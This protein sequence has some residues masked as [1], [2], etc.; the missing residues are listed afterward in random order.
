MSIKKKILLTLLLVLF[1][2][3]SLVTSL[4]VLS[5]P[6]YEF[7]ETEDGG[8]QFE[9]FNGN[10]E[11]T[12]LHID[13]VLEKTKTSQGTEWVA[14][15]SRPITSVRS[16]TVASVE[17]L[18]DVYIGAAV[19][20][21]G[22]AAF[23]N[24]WNLK[25]Y[26]V[27]K[28]NKY[29]CDVD[30]VLF[31][32]DMKVLV[33]YPPAKCKDEGADTTYAIPAG[34]E[35]L[36]D[37]SF[38]KC[39][40]L[41]EVTIPEGVKE[42]GR[43]VFFKCWDLNLVELPSTIETLGPDCFSFC[44]SMKYAFFIPASMKSIDHHAFYKSDALE[45]FYVECDES[46]ISLGSKWMPKSENSFSAD[47]AV[48][49]AARSE[50]EAYNAKRISEEKP[51]VE[52]NNP[53]SSDN[54]D[55]PMNDKAVILLI[56]FVFIPGFIMIGIEVIRKLFKED[57]LMT[58]NGRAKLEKIKAEKEAIHLAYVNGEYADEEPELPP[59]PS[60]GEEDDNNG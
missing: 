25:A 52:E 58:K 35:R 57:F 49:S 30:G 12:E 3:T 4:N 41:T 8:W 16:N 24:L 10:A 23:T 36:A 48:F 31:T 18:T 15:E 11:I 45:A 53:E 13:K 55:N 43:M 56:I 26:H 19:K 51:P 27:D 20:D 14:D 34:V 17:Y 29:Y 59:E 22:E 1:V 47:D 2:G 40:A 6:T 9:G 33:S 54:S 32:K 50:Y 7:K 28:A 37:N 46:D 21:I 38:Y 39:D 60:Q 44:T 42:I 5:R